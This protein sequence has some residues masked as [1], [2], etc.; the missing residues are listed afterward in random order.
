M[1]INLKNYQEEAVGKLID[2]FKTLLTN[3]G[4]NKVCVFQ[5]PTGSGKT[6][7]VLFVDI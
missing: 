2:S 5:A 7:N 1:N 4:Q 3:E 6:I